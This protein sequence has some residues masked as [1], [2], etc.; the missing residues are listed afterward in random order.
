MTGAFKICANHAFTRTIWEDRHILRS[1]NEDEGRRPDLT[2]LNAPH[3]NGHALL[4]DIS[5]VQA[6]RGSRN[7][8]L[9]PLR[10]P[11]DHYT[12]ISQNPHRRTSAVA[13][14]S[15][16]NKCQDVCTANGAS[17]LPII[18]ESNGYIYPQ[19]RQFLQYLAKQAAFYRHIPW[20]NLYLFYLSLISVSLQSTLYRSLLTH[21]NALHHPSPLSIILTDA[22]IAS[23]HL[24]S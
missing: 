2:I 19:A 1:A 9:S 11:P 20:H 3:Q 7:S 12:T 24:H 13:Y 4:F 10:H 18:I 23:A 16:I 17:F 8:T 14:I 22:D 21:I 5:I 15:K 6:F